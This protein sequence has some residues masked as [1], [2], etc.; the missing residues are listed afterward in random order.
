MYEWYHCTSGAKMFINHV[1]V[2]MCILRVCIVG[3][4]GL[5]EWFLIFLF[6]LKTRLFCIYFF[7][8]FLQSLDIM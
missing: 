7:F 4:N 8:S 2:C 6:F 3:L 1:M 5:Y